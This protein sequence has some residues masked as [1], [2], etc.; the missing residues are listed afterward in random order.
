MKA[1]ALRRWAYGQKNATWRNWGLTSA[2]ELDG[3]LDLGA[4]GMVLGSPDQV[5]GFPLSNIMQVMTVR[6]IAE[7]SWETNI[8]VAFVTTD[9]KESCALEI[10]C[11]VCQFYA[12][13]P[14]KR[15]ATVN[16]DRA[17]L[18]KWIFGQTTFDEAVSDGDIAIDGEAAT[19]AD[20]LAKFEPF[21]Q[22]EEIA[23]AAR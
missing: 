12:I 10:R 3:E 20:F 14:D 19:V 17:F 13:P 18:I 2:K 21:N 5:R 7:E 23:I 8:R 6:L 4:S 1:E 15:D 11:G 22:T 9:S 16:F